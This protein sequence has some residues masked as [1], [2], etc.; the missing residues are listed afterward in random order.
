MVEFNTNQLAGKRELEAK[1]VFYNHIVPLAEESFIHDG[2]LAPMVFLFLDDQERDKVA[3][4]PMP[5][6]MFMESEDKKELLSG[7]L[8]E[9]ADKLDV[10][11]IGMFS[12]AWM[13]I[14]NTKTG[15]PEGKEEICF[16]SF[17]S[18]NMVLMK[19]NIV[20]RNAEENTISF[21]YGDVD[22]DTNMTGKFVGFLKDLK[23]LKQN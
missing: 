20:V 4:A 16:F 23:K 22:T 14:M 2:K 21:N 19:R 5:A 13:T 1:D 6:D 3:I 12:E 17:E 10:I 9:L 7:L 15:E 18:E 11:A 8:H